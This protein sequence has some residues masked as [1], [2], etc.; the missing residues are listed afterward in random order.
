MK[1]ASFYIKQ[2]HQCGDLNLCNFLGHPVHGFMGQPESDISIRLSVL[3]VAIVPNTQTHGQT[4]R[5]TD[6]RTTL[7]CTQQKLRLA[8]CAAMRANNGVILN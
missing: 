8:L 3:Q 6:R 7:Q 4:D 1:S 5:Q 2:L